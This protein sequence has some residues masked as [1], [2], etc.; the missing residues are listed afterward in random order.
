MKKS[1]PAVRLSKQSKAEFLALGVEIADL[2]GA[3][4]S[5]VK[6]KKSDTANAS[7]YLAYSVPLRWIYCNI[8]HSTTARFLLEGGD[9]SE[10]TADDLA[11][12]TPATKKIHELATDDK[13]AS[14][15]KVLKQV[16]KLR[17]ITPLEIFTGLK[18]KPGLKNLK[19]RLS[20][21]DSLIVKIEAGMLD[22]SDIARLKTALGMEAD[23]TA[24]IEAD[25]SSDVEADST[26]DIEADSAV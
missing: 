13:A 24:D 15:F 17:S 23:S 21:L 12:A 20:A 5:C 1:K 6:S 9:V 22:Q 10:I 19:P 8:N 26:A 3:L 4:L 25:S 16:H 7:A 11:N 2:N 14:T 18:A